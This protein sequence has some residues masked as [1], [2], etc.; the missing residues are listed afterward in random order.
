[1]RRKIAPH[2]KILL[3]GYPQYFESRPERN[4]P[5]MHKKEFNTAIFEALIFFNEILSRKI[6]KY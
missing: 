3:R 2:Q 4:G 5:A 6:C 1:M